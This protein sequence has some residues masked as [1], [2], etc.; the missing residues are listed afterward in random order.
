M[1]LN[2]S[3]NLSKPFFMNRKCRIKGWLAPL[4]I[5]NLFQVLNVSHLE[6]VS[7]WPDGGPSLPDPEVEVPV[8]VTVELLDRAG[9]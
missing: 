9:S 2:G 6:N 5:K 3:G 4:L 8:I 1:I 7:M